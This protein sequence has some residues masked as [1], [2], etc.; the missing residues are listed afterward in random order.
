MRKLS[1][2]IL[3]TQDECCRMNVVGLSELE[4]VFPCPFL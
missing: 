4:G 3:D 1:L 2:H